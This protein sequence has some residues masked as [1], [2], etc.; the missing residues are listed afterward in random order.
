MT[1]LIYKLKKYELGFNYDRIMNLIEISLY[2]FNIIIMWGK[3]N[4]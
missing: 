3:N 2:F 1:I 4:D